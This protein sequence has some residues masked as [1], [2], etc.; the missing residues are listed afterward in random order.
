VLGL[1]GY[2]LTHRYPPPAHPPPPAAA[3]VPAPDPPA[4][5]GRRGFGPPGLRVVVNGTR[6]RLVDLNTAV[7]A[8]VP[9]LPTRTSSRPYQYAVP[10][11]T[12]L[13]VYS[14]GA[15]GTVDSYLA[16]PGAPPRRVLAGGWALPGYG[17]RTLV[18]V[19][20]HRGDRGVTVSGLPLPGSGT[21]GR[22]LWRWQ[23]RSFDN[24]VL[25][26]RYG[27][28]TQLTGPGGQ[29][30]VVRRETGRVLRSFPGDAVAIGDRWVAQL[31]RPGCS[32]DCRLVLRPLAGGASRQFP[33]AAEPA[34]LVGRFSS[35]GRWLALAFPAGPQV[36]APAQSPGWI[37]VL[38][39]Q[40]GALH[41][42]AGLVT[43]P[44]RRPILDWSP[45]GRSLVVG[46]Q[47]GSLLRLGVW[48]ADRPGDPL[49]V[50]PAVP[51]DRAE[52]AITTLP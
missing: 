37:S 12:G 13:I 33:L 29:I 22:T 51:C 30:Q 39:L 11:R 43:P 21:G 38:D 36:G 44:S 8:P 28:V 50:L 16:L 15:D 25:D 3:A 18:A 41:R 23:A 49:T 31:A 27:L 5:T 52:T 24:P 32:G 48:A 10:F 2:V 47:D 35:D 14:D 17:G 6:P 46:I 34:A 7:E 45:D 40:T 9:G 4:I 42:V 26:T 19:T 20:V 1:L